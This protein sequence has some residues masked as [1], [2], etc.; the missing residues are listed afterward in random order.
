MN[1]VLLRIAPFAALISAAACGSPQCD[2]QNYEPQAG[3]PVIVRMDILQ[4]LAGDPWTIV[5][6]LEFSDSE[7]DIGGGQVSFYLN[8]D[9][10]PT[11]LPLAEYFAQSD[12]PVNATSG[13]FALQLRFRNTVPDGD[14]VRLAAQLEDASA[15]VKGAAAGLRSNCYQMDL[16]FDVQPVARAA[17]AQAQQFAQ[18]MFKLFRGHS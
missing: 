6:A 18:H 11:T 10:T 16:R 9:K 4:Q 14:R 12:L 3:S 8:S 13:R 1:A 5:L 2:G 15:S 17:R 7:G